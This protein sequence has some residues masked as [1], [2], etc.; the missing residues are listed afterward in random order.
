MILLDRM[1]LIWNYYNSNNSLA[2]K[3][4]GYY[5]MRGNY[6]AKIKINFADKR[7]L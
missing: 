6:I 1:E 2:R 7:M 5:L 3:F 4:E